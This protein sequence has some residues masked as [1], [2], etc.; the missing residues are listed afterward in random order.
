MLKDL[1]CCLLFLSFSSELYEFFWNISFLWYKSTFYGTIKLV[2][3][4]V[5]E[6]WEINPCPLLEP[7]T[8][9]EW[10]DTHAHWRVTSLVDW[11]ILFFFFLDE[12]KVFILL[13]I[14][15]LLFLPLHCFVLKVDQ[16][17]D[18]TCWVRT[19]SSNIVLQF[20]RILS[21]FLVFL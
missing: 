15:L 18:N 5:S 13:G 19:V 11:Y 10:G 16:A 6:S 9:F 8:E 7:L 4:L 2:V 17:I 1:R 20:L 12:T 21:R 3:L 14:C